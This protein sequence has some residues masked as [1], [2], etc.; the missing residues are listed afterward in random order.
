MRLGVLRGVRFD[1][2]GAAQRG[3]ALRSRVAARTFVCRVFCCGLLWFVVCLLVIV[4]L[5]VLRL[6]CCGVVFFVLCVLVWFIYLCV[7]V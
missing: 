5:F 1:A 2:V 7:C 6:L 4:L 3:V